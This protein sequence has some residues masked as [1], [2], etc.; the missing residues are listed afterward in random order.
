M[1]IFIFNFLCVCAAL[2]ILY[3][4]LA[5]TVEFINAIPILREI[6][7]GILFLIIVVAFI[8]GSLYLFHICI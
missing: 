6:V 3:L 7:G 8:C 5:G 4:I 2:F 1:M